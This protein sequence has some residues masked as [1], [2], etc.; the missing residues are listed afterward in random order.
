MVK[1]IELLTPG[2]TE[3]LYAMAHYKGSILQLTEEVRYLPLWTLG[4]I[5]PLLIETEYKGVV[6]AGVLSAIAIT[7]LTQ[8][9][10]AKNL[11]IY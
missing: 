7:I 4:R 10:I 8:R 6:P 9:A 1:L 2:E 3:Q 5:A 11:D